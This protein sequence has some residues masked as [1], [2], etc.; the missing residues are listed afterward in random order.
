VLQC[1]GA[2]AALFLVED[3]VAHG[4]DDSMAF[5]VRLRAQTTA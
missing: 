3:L 5:R 2:S 1:L 4:R